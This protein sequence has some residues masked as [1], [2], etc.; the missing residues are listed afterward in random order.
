MANTKVAFTK[1][2]HKRVRAKISGDKSRPRFSVHK[3][4]KFIYAQLIDDT[5]GNTLA[6]AKGKKADEVG[7]EIAKKAKTK[8]I[9]EVIFDR[10]GHKYHGAIAKLAEAARSG[11][12]KF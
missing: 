3:S 10:G 7:M 12:L 2:R 9:T 8:R 6:S 11:G 4:N 1:I 5:K